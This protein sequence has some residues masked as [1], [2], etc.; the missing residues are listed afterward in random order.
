M[1]VWGGVGWCGG[2][3]LFCWFWLEVW[4]TVSKVLVAKQK[5]QKRQQKKT[6]ELGSDWIWGERFFGWIVDL[7]HAWPG[8]GFSPTRLKNMRKSNWITTAG[9]S[10]CW[11]VGFIKNPKNLGFNGLKFH[12]NR[13]VPSPN[14]GLHKPLIRP[15]G[16]FLGGVGWPFRFPVQFTPEKTWGK[17]CPPLEVQRIW[18]N[19]TQIR[20]LFDDPG[21]AAGSFRS[22]EK[23]GRR[24]VDL[25][26][27]GGFDVLLGKKHSASKIWSE[28]SGEWWW[29]VCFWS[30]L[31]PVFFLKKQVSC[32]MGIWGA[33][34]SPMLR[35]PQ[36]NIYGLFSMDFPGSC[37]GW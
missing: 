27:F 18:T 37:K 4:K 28:I 19:L 10:W 34:P 12:G 30:S 7:G 3:L 23:G 31:Q 5:P 17:R 11:G 33:H 20:R 32:F 13:R 9:N 25:D 35:F 29:T 16:L 14:D 26:F 24:L 6:V 15:G 2:G 8:G 1:F 36:G 22:D 21:V